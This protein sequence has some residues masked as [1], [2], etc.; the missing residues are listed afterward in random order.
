VAT[1]CSAVL[2]LR[3]GAGP[4][5]SVFIYRRRGDSG[6]GAHTALGFFVGVLSRRHPSGDASYAA[7]LT[8]AG[9]LDGMANGAAQLGR[10]KRRVVR[11]CC[12]ARCGLDV[13]YSHVRESTTSAA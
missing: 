2:C 3:C 4:D 1:A 12:L 13:C 11:A 10:I 6:V 9:P 7:Q 5:V 8:T